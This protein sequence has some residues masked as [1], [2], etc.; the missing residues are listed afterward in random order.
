M[1]S[2][3]NKTVL[4]VVGTRPEVIKLAPVIREFRKRKNIKCV[5]CATGQHQEMANQVFAAFGILPDI[6]LGLMRKR[7]SL[8]NL[9]SRAITKLETVFRQVS[10]DLVVVQGDTTT[11]LCASLVAFYN[12]VDVAHVEA[13]L[14][15]GNMWS[16]WPEEAN[17]VLTTRLTALHFAPTEEARVALRREGVSAG[18]IWVTGNTVIDALLWAMRG[19]RANTIK[20]KSKL[21]R[22]YI[23]VTM[24]RRENMGLGI[25]NVCRAIAQIASKNPEID[26]VIPVHKNP[27]VRDSIF[28]LLGKSAKASNIKLIE[29]APYLEFVRLMANS[30]II[31]TDS[32]GVQEEAPTLGVPVLV[33]RESTER[34]EALA[35]GATRL[36]GTNTKRIVET[37]T[38]LLRNREVYRA[39]STAGNPYGDGA[40]AVRIVRACIAHLK[41][42]G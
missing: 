21:A 6:N 16:P 41:K 27:S 18:K 31:L 42:S 2:H 38:E 13:G 35:C 29:P 12:C 28:E 15:T 4:V 39:M 17:R 34:P 24:H 3:P 19:K 36:V 25:E 9:S 40:A 7:Q 1:K 14:R 20:Q 23:L 37:V 32:G 11:V 22:K 33:L 26:I 10:P 5:V 30:H 8:A